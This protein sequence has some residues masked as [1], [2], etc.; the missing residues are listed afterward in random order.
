MS[1]LPV[2]VYG[3]IRQLSIIKEIE[4][5]NT[6]SGIQEGQVVEVKVKE[7][8]PSGLR[9]ELTAN[10]RK[11]FVTRRE[12]SSDRSVRTPLKFP[13]PGEKRSAIILDTK[14]SIIRLSLRQVIDPWRDV[15]KYKKYQE[16]E[17]ITGEVVNVR[18]NAAYIQVE[19]GIDAKIYPRDASFSKKNIE[20]V[21]WVGDK[22]RGEVI[23]CDSNEHSI[24]LSIVRALRKLRTDD[25]S[26][27][28]KKFDYPPPS[29]RETKNALSSLPKEKPAKKIASLRTREIK[30]VLLVDNDLGWLEFL[31]KQITERYDSLVDTVSNSDDAWEKIEEGI[32]YDL[33]LID[34]QLDHE[35]G[36]EF[37]KELKKEFDF[38]I[39]LISV[40]L[41]DISLLAQEFNDISFAPKTEE[42]VAVFDAI[43]QI[44]LGKSI[45]T[46]ILDLSTSELPEDILSVIH[47]SET[48]IRS[49]LAW[50]YNELKPTHCLFL[51]LHPL[52]QK[53]EIVDAYPILSDDEK[54]RAEDGLFY[55]PARQ[56]IEEEHL[57]IKN[58]VDCRNDR[59]YKNFFPSLYFQ[60]LLGMPVHIPGNEPSHALVIL[61]DELGAF[62]DKNS[63]QQAYIAANFLSLILE[64]I[65]TSNILERYQQ[66]Y[67]M[68]MLLG[69]FVHEIGNRM[70]DLE[71]SR[72]RLEEKMLSLPDASNIK[73]V[74]FWVKAVQGS[75]KEINIASKDLRILN[76]AYTR[77][78]KL[79]YEA[80]DIN[81]LLLRIM[82]RLA[83]TEAKTSVT[84]YKKFYK[85]LPKANSISDNLRQVF[86][87][88]LLNAV[89]M[90]N[91]QQDI[92]KME[93]SHTTRPIPQKRGVIIVQTLYNEGSK[94]PN[95][96]RIIDNGPGIHWRD[97]KNIFL[98]GFSHRGGAGLGLHISQNVVRRIGG[99]LVLLD[100]ILFE[101]SVFSVELPVFS[102]EEQDHD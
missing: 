20:D 27:L 6:A 52:E 87:N 68:G 9:V 25:K 70:Q 41:Q 59:R 74:E 46:D 61:D 33:I 100:S 72:E 16:G 42:M 50:L 73:T 86:T 28:L 82:Q 1:N 51:K 24:E 37:A 26:D 78:I 95:E 47:V 17:I 91:R 13:E 2:R 67:T 39:L 60:S 49:M 92:W 10:G 55:S 84:I 53:I 5:G 21:L 15:I 40:A 56:I 77:Q 29:K 75:I 76:D 7:S 35:D 38:P 14:G 98:Q 85:N 30:R 63:Y 22:I 32:V 99:R 62:W 66:T 93:E 88:L 102:E 81:A 18:H 54:K 34:I 101:G 57:L 96:V 58:D 36:R 69:D 80:V 11:G 31:K 83:G 89:Q 19:P 8:L 23:R 48:D 4:M 90:I 45:L 44:R 71:I 12:I 94:Y 65:S 3:D 97:Q 43:D 64:R 79:Q